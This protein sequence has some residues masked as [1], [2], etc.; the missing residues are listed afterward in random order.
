M[1]Q[2]SHEKTITF[3]DPLVILGFIAAIYFLFW[4]T[5]YSLHTQLSTVYVYVRYVELWWLHLLGRAIDVPGVSNIYAWLE[6]ACSPDGVLGLCRRDFA[7]LKWKDIT[8]SSWIINLGFMMALIT[9]CVQMFRKANAAHPK[10]KYIQVH[11]IESFVREK[12]QLYPHLKM[13]SEIDLIA[14]P[15]DHALFGMSLTS[16]QFVFKHQLI[17]GWKEEAG[18]SLGPTLDRGKAT[19]IFRAQLGKH[20][21]KSTELSVGETLLVAIAVPRIVATDSSLEDNAFDEAMRESREMIQWCWDQFVAPSPIEKAEATSGVDR[22]GWLHPTIDL[23]RPR[24]TILKYIAHPNVQIILERHAYSRTV[25]VALFIQARRLGVLQPAE[26]RWMRFFDRELWY[27]LE[28]IGR[29]AAFV[30]A[31]GV[32][33]HYLYEVKTGVA[34]AE[35]QLDKAVNGLEAAINNFKFSIEDRERY[36]VERSTKNIS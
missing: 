4:A 35:P 16:R 22:Y 32:L 20:W 11:T 27:V 7:T 15:L 6:Q 3:D 30:E 8:D 12:K 26:M 36:E 34:L 29:Q 33:S 10:L 21:T 25:I 9:L 14:E 23:T 24:E 1:K 19:A 18:G 28:N 2:G 31:A 5:W 13:F 17:A